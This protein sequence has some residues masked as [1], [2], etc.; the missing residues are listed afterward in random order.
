MLP[1]RRREYALRMTTV[2][3]KHADVADA[4]RWTRRA[5]ALAVLTVAY[6]LV[7][8][9]V[10]VGLGVS[11][12]SIA[13]FGFGV[14]SFIEVASALLVLWRFRGEHGMGSAPSLERERRATLGIGALFVALAAG[15]SF[16]SLAQ[17]AAREH[18]ATT[19]PGVVIAAISLSFMVF[20]WRAKL[21][22]ARAL[23]SSTV[24]KDAACSRACIQLSVV[25][26]AGSLAFALFPALWWVDAAAALVLAALI[27]REG[28][29]TIRAARQPQFCGG[30][31]CG[32]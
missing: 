18:P 4:S 15:T 17:L 31:G 19:T 21:S 8:G 14:D 2:A 20:L 16:G 12:E 9:L 7:E 27:G 11:E 3:V 24:E 30:C 10:S 22:T 26:L 1:A 13:L 28:V 23:N 32:H 29:G 5:I 25:L 6:N